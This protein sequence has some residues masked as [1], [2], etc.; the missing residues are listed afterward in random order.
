VA[1]LESDRRAAGL[2]AL[3]I[4]AEP[5]SDLCRKNCN[6]CDTAASRRA[7]VIPKQI[8]E[9]R[10]ERQ[11][12]GV[13]RRRNIPFEPTDCPASLTDTGILRASEIPYEKEAYCVRRS[14]LRSFGRRHHHGHDQRAAS[15]GRILQQPYR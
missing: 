15:F 6:L 10:W 3:A 14:R 13:A 5:I 1:A 12:A 11:R 4:L 9:A 8:G 2:S 7:L